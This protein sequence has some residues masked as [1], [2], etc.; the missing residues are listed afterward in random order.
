MSTIQV[1]LEARSYFIT[2]GNGLLGQT[3][4]LLKESQPARNTIVISSKTI[5]S[6]HGERLFRSSA[7]RWFPGR[8]GHHSRRRKS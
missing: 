2:V 7:P 4:S 6:L 5:L 8:N 3:G 1:A